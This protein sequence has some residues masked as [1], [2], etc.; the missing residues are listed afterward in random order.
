MGGIV[1]NIVTILT[2]N[3]TALDMDRPCLEINYD[4]LLSGRVR[5]LRFV[6]GKIILN[7]LGCGIASEK[8]HSKE[9]TDDLHAIDQKRQVPTDLR[10]GKKESKRSASSTGSEQKQEVAK[11][12]KVMVSNS[13]LSE[14]ATNNHELVTDKWPKDVPIEGQDSKKHQGMLAEDIGAV[15]QNYA[16]KMQERH[17]SRELEIKSVLETVKYKMTQPGQ[18]IEDQ[19][20]GDNQENKKIDKKHLKSLKKVNDKVISKQ[21]KSR[22]KFLQQQEFSEQFASTI[23][24]DKTTPSQTKEAFKDVNGKQ[25]KIEYKRSQETLSSLFR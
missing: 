18:L 20:L 3:V 1:K 4:S 13:Y 17:K 14:G 12:Q 15:F 11:K 22:E 5:E 8:D 10:E 6:L 2:L 25:T 19:E 16:S 23:K 21:R 24:A 9:V 7:T